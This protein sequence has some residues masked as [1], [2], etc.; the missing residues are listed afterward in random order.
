MISTVIAKPTKLCNADCQYCSTPPDGRG[1]WSLDDFKRYFD[2]V[3]PRLSG[4]AVWLW[5]GGEPMLMGPDFYWKAYEHARQACPQIR[6]SM[7]TNILAY[8]TSQWKEILESV[9]KRSVST[10]Y[11]PD[12]LNRTMK[13]SAERF[14]RVF[15]A[16]LDQMLADGFR[17][18]VIGT[19]TEESSP[20]ALSLYERSLARGREAFS[21]RFNYR[22]PVGRAYGEG[23][24]ISPQTYGSMLLRIY[25]RWIKDN[26]PFMIT[27]LDEMLGKVIGTEGSRCP[28]T[29][30]CGGRFLSIDPDG[31][32]YNCAEFGSLGASLS[33]MGQ[34]DPYRY[35][36]LNS[37]TVEQLLASPA[38]SD[39]RRRRV[40]VPQ[41]CRTCRHFEQCEGG[42]ARDSALYGRGMGGKFYY[43]D[44]WMMVFDRIKE[45]VL[46]GEADAV[47]R[48][49]FKRDP[50]T[51]RAALMVQQAPSP[52]GA[53]RVASV[54][55]A[56]LARPTP[57]PEAEQPSEQ[58][59]KPEPKIHVVTF[60]RKPKPEADRV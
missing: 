6:F 12:E 1:K 48:D 57:A 55:R 16:K 58:P 37:H 23:E 3:A 36:N 33:E 2:A 25:D 20:L 52:T 7:Q 53:I 15:F 11:D 19:Y 13:G 22:Y 17:P 56:S 54:V 49:K 32:V 50:E 60:H 4:Q 14:H 27:P 31:S 24:A 10:S 38:A 40:D 26:P 42:C 47:I 29:N 59:V 51:A 39:M 44:S 43:C 30:S 45:S 18:S 9:F 35:G 28:W 41:S 21:L 34:P 46:S 5:H 8:S